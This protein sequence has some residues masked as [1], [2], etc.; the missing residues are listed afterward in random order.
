MSRAASRQKEM[1]VLL[2]TPS[3]G[4]GSDLLSRAKMDLDVSESLRPGP[5]FDGWIHGWPTLRR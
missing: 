1:A 3:N 5:P 2:L 4:A